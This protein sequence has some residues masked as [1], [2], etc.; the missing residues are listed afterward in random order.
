MDRSRSAIV[1]AWV[2]PVTDKPALRVLRVGAG[3]TWLAPAVVA[4]SK[5]LHPELSAR[6]MGADQG[7][8]GRNPHAATVD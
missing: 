3:W 1:A 6:T 7:R 5:D 4:I 2:D 8:N